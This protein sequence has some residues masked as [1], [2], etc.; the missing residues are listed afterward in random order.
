M[1]DLMLEVECCGMSETGAL[2][3][4][5][6]VFFDWSKCEMGPTFFRTIHLATSVRDGGTMDAST[7]IWWLRQG[8]DARKSVAY[9]GQDVRTVLQDFSNWIATTCRHEDVRPW[10]NSASFDL[11]KVRSACERADIKAPWYWS[12]ERCFRTVRHLYPRVPY[13][14]EKKGDGAHN[15]L[16]D[17]IFQV[18]HLFACKR[19]YR[20]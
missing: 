16:T 11:P 13:E 8:D 2:M 19:E 7:V 14:P 15:A 12:N 9:N 18:E 3:A 20:K 1:F 6:A 10:A 17:A 5:G 4:L